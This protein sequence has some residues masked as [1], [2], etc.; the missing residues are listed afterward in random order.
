M[1]TFDWA[2][3]CVGG[4]KDWPQSLKTAVRVLLDCQLPM[5]L[6]WGPDFV[7][8]YN[9]AYVPILGNKDDD[10]L[11]KDARHTW[12][13]IWP[14]IGP[15]W[16]NVLQ[17]KGVGADRFKLTIER[18]GYPEDCYFSFSYSPIPDDNGNAAGVLVTF[19][20]TT[21][22]VLAEQRQA[23]HLSL[24]D[25][26]RNLRDPVAITELA[27]AMLGQYLGA[28]RAGYG[29]INVGLG[30][31]TVQRDWTDGTMASLAGESRPLDGFGPQ[32]IAELRAGRVLRLD[33]ISADPRSAPYA[34]GYASIGTKSLLIIPLLKEGVLAAVLYLHCA[35]PHRWQDRDVGIAEDVAHRTWDAVERAHAEHGLIEADRRKDEFLAM[36]AHELRNPLAP[37][38][39]AAEILKMNTDGNAKVIRASEVISRQARHL[40][41]LVNDLLDVSRV[42]KGLVELN[43]IDIDLKAAIENAVEQSKPL[44]D[45][46]G[47]VLV[48]RN[49]VSRLIVTGDRTR[50]VQAFSN[51]LN[52]A[53]KYTPEGG[54]ITLAVTREDKRAVVEVKDNGIGIDA[55]LLPHVFDLFTQAQRTPD[56]AQ[57]GLGIGLALVKTIVTLHAGEI[58]AYSLGPGEG[59]K[60]TVSLPLA[61]EG[62]E[63][64]RFP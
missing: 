50:L 43:K 29:E 27:A 24:S 59:S 64:P 36:L 58:T 45:S 61:D 33:D 2:R 53:G 51:L 44:L 63:P 57:G 23:F 3:T 19:A 26:L 21:N 32:I 22:T 39:S 48:V 13:E 62:L 9:D 17:G 20:E 49:D 56:R 41:A 12:S 28:G 10:A 25:A 60:F 40:T 31:V 34:S 54:E 52:N 7:Q 42:T 14:T 18:Y 15:M 16:A 55:D 6:A 38:C 46:K 11:G 47:H 4:T 35:E 5:Y 8:F 30:T 37:I 1:R